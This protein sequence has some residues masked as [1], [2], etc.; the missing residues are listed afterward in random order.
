[1][2]NL[3]LSKAELVIVI[4]VL[5]FVIGLCVGVMVFGSL[6]SPS[7]PDLHLASDLAA[8]SH[9][10]AHRIPPDPGEATDASLA[11]STPVRSMTITFFTV[12]VAEMGDKTQLATML[13]SAQ[14][15][16]PWAIFLGSAGALVT[17]SLVSVL[18]GEGLAQVLPPST[19]QVLAGLGFVLI[20]AYVLLMEVWGGESH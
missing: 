20:G 13:M 6:G 7:L 8:V 9:L 15:R 2:A 5:V 18:L 17:A 1:M 4:A 19:L 11:L 3:K 12:F 16:S 14:S 10:D